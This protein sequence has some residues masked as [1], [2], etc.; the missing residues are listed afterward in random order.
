MG[1]S[2]GIHVG[3]AV[4]VALR[5]AASGIAMT[6]ALVTTAAAQ[7][8]ASSAAA[9]GAACATAPAPAQREQACAAMLKAGT[10]QPKDAALTH[11]FRGFALRDLKQDDTALAEF[12][13][14]AKLD[15]DLWPA[16][17]VRAELLSERRYY[18]KAAATWAQVIA[19]NPDLASLY[20]HRGDAFDNQGRRAE[21]VA[22]YTKAIELARPKDPIAR[23]YMNRA[24]SYEGDRQWEKALADYSEAIKRD[25]HLARAYFGRG[26]VEFLRGDMSVAAADLT[27][28]FESDPADY[29]PLLWLFLA[30]SHGGKDAAVDLRRRA[31]QLD[32]AK[33]PGPILRV[34]LGDLAPEQVK[35]PKQSQAWTEAE[36]KAGSD[37]ELSF[38]LGELRLAKGDRGRALALFKAALDTGIHEFIEYAAASYELERTAR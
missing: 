8:P 6:V 23:F 15:P 27:K 30:K 36:Q 4:G 16:S 2:C 25:D 35:Q 28:A 38:Y 24:V 29:Y 7:T 5:A 11:Y 13:E 32:L 22:D 31:S 9:T 37:C 34:Y 26:R 17:W 14:A 20:D 12:S 21:A 19:R 10:L 18:D 1:K 33:W 3:R